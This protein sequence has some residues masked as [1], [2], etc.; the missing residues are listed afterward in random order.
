MSL[1]FTA[2]YGPLAQVGLEIAS[3]PT[4]VQLATGAYGWYKAKERT[5][6]LQQMLSISGG[7][8]V[9]TSSFNYNFYKAIRQDH[10]FMQ[11]V[12]VQD[13]K[14]QQ[15]RLPKGSSAIPQDSGAACLRAVTA[16]LLCLLD[17]EAVVEVL[18]DVIPHSMVQLNQEGAPLVIEGTLLTSLKQQVSAVALEEDSDKFRQFMLERVR[19]R[20]SRMIRNDTGDI[21]DFVHSSVNELPLLIG[22]LRWILMPLHQR[23]FEKY[24]TRSLKVWTVALIMEILGFE[25]QVDPTVTR[26]HHNEQEE[27]LPG[28]P[29]FGEAAPVF[30]VLVSGLETDPM[31]LL[32]VPHSSDIPKPQITMIRAIPWVAF[33]HLRGT[34]ANIST[35]YLS[36][37]WNFSYRSAR[38]CF[39]CVTIEM[40]E[41]RIVVGETDTIGIPEHQKALISDFSPQLEQVCAPAMRHFLPMS[42][43]SAG[44]CLSDIREQMKVLGHEDDLSDTSSFC[45]DNCYI[46]YAIVCATIYGLCSK[47]CFDKGAALSEDSEVA[48]SPEIMY[49]S[50]GRKVKEWAK[51]VGHAIHGS[52][53]SSVPLSAWSDLIFELFLGKDTETG[54]LASMTTPSNTTY[55]N[56]QNP[57]RQRLYLGAQANGLSAVA[58]VLVTISTRL[59]SFCYFHISRGQLLNFPLTE[60]HYVE[61]STYIEPAST[62]T[63]D[64]DP[65]NT[66][67]HRFEFDSSHYDLRIDVEPCWYDNPR[68]ILFVLRSG[69]VPIAR[70]NIL[71]FV[72]RMS[73][74]VVECNCRNKSWNVPVRATEQWQLV[75]LSQL[76]RTRFKGMSAK[77]VDVSLTDHKILIDGSHSV[78]ATIYA[79]CI[80]HSRHLLVAT[81][82]LLCAYNRAMLNWQHSDAAIITT[83]QE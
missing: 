61:A 52:Q 63:L 43:S 24:P 47:I 66:L 71:A 68:K 74:D 65:N 15:T 4:A 37:V 2:N 80:L 58:D 51:T 8:L 77:R 53:R 50:A 10:T 16:G 34:S 23:T 26:D 79:I 18:Q 44:W 57:N 48:F 6:S 81:Q 25:V 83:L 69:G 45:R 21:V 64:P 27:S 5:K 13:H 3:L 29:R 20:Q 49:R 11:G 72:D 46:L 7:Q 54:M 12:V 14:V 70:L 30:L 19:D 39:R 40:Q 17:V 33:R 76:M 22:V 59:E 41:V 75:T 38:A 73:Y 78:A 32:H 35:Q 28:V 31:P 67:L 62:I 42:A 36:D 56:S 1:S 55:M 82:C 60:E 9:S